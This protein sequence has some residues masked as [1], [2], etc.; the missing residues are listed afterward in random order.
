MASRPVESVPPPGGKATMQRIGRLGQVS[1]A[2]DG[3]RRQRRRG[4]GKNR[5]TSVFDDHGHVFNRV[6]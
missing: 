4:A 5:A 3:R 1:R 2:H 6:L